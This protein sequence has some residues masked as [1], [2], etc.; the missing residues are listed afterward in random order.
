MARA[1]FAIILALLLHACG[2]STSPTSPSAPPA[3]VTAA[4]C[5][6]VYHPQTVTFIGNNTFIQRPAYIQRVCTDAAGRETRTCRLATGET[7][8][9][10]PAS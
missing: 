3:P 7:P 9:A 10:C 6:E 1:T 2:N 4:T 8:I 5:R